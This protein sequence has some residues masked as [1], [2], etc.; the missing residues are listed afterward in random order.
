[1]DRK[2]LVADVPEVQVRVAAALA[3][4]RVVFAHTLAAAL[5]ALAAEDFDHVLIGMHFDDSRMFDL[6]AK[7]A[8]PAVIAACGSSATACGRSPS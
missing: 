3:Q 1:M 6:R 2:V 5:R 7:C 4:E 8:P